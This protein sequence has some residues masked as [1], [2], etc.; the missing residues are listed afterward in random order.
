VQP[1]IEGGDYTRF[2]I[3]SGARTGSTVLAQAL[4]SSPDIICFREV[5]NYTLNAIDYS[6][7][8]YDNGSAEDLARRTRDPIAFLRERIFCHHP[9]K[10]KAVGFKFHYL[11]FWG[12]PGLWEALAEDTQLRVLHLKRHNLLRMLLSLRIAESTGVWQQEPGRPFAKAAG[13]AKEVKRKLTPANVLRAFREPQVAAAWVRRLVNPPKVYKT[14]P[15]V[16]ATVSDEEL[17]TFITETE[18][19]SAHF[20]GLFREHPKLMISYEDMLKDNAETF[21]RAQEFLGIEP[22]PLTVTLRR[23][24]PEPLRDLMQNYDELCEAF[25]DTPHAWMF[26]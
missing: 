12:F 2:I 19:T 15:R 4:N 24:N 14:A 23:Q 18:A 16:P 11:H 20:D 13:Q 22:K 10:V 7:D 6:V 3:L 1:A 25:R 21:S 26:E 5:F 9:D 8:G 17:R